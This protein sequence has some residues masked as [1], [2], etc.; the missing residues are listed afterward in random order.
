MTTKFLTTTAAVV[1]ASAAVTAGVAFAQGGDPPTRSANVPA[2]GVS[3]GSARGME[4]VAM[5][6][7]LSEA[8]VAKMANGMGMKLDTASVQRMTRHHNAMMNGKGDMGGKGDMSGMAGQGDMSGS[9]GDMS[10]KGSM[11]GMS[12]KGSMDGMKP[13]R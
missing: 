1:A 12:G 11:D 7:R 9:Q 13:G 3:G 10:G 6:G 5:G 4:G 8:D 2:Q